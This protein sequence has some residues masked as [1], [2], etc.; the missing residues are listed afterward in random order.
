MCWSG[1]WAHSTITKLIWNI[2]GNFDD[3]IHVS[4]SFPIKD[5]WSNSVS[6]HQITVGS[7]RHY[8][9]FQYFIGVTMIALVPDIPEIV[10]GIQFSLQNNI[11]LRYVYTI[12]WEIYHITHAGALYNRLIEC[13]NVLTN[14]SKQIRQ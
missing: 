8:V 9:P 3:S 11:S 1:Y 5:E 14:N 6:L 13:W 12:S 10:T 2:S 7:K 4:Y